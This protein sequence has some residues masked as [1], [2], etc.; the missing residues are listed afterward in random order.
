LIVFVGACG[1]APA[2]DS[3]TQQKKSEFFAVHQ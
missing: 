3:N 2:Q 1:S